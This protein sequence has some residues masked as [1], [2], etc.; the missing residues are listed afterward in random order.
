VPAWG[1]VLV[2]IAAFAAVGLLVMLALGLAGAPA[3]SARRLGQRRGLRR[4]VYRGT[5]VPPEVPETVDERED[6]DPDG[7]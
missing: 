6:A 4:H 5:E 3:D 1:W 2:G 7:R